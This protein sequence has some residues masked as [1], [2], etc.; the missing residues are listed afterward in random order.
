M[1]EPQ[2]DQTKD[3]LIAEARALRERLA[4]LESVI[5]TI[6]DAVYVKDLAGRYQVINSACARL[7]G[8]SVSEVI[9]KD[10][11]ELF[12]PGAAAFIMDTDRRVIA[13][14]TTIKFEVDASASG[15]NRSYLN[16][17]GPRFGT[18]DDVTGVIGIS[19]DVTEQ[20]RT[21]RELAR[22]AEM[23]WAIFEHIPVMIHLGEPDGRVKLVNRHWENVLGWPLEEARRI[24]IFAECYPDPEYRRQVL[25]CARNV[26]PGWH[27][28]RTRVRDGRVIDTSWTGTVLSD[29]TRIWFGQDVTDRK[30]GERELRTLTR[31]VVEVQEE[32]RRHLARELHDEIGQT[33]TA[34][35]IN[36]QAVKRSA[37]DSGSVGLD[38][39]INIV[40]RAI[41]QVRDLSLGLRPSVLDDLGLVAALRWHLDQQAQLVGYAAH[42]AA[43]PG[44]IALEPAA[45]IA[46]F[47][48]A[49]E[50]LTNVA[51]HA[52]A[53]RVA[54]KLR[55]RDETLQLAVL[56]DGVGFDP[57][58]NGA[59]LGLAGMRERAALLG[60]SVDVRSA[61]GRGTR[62][63]LKLAVEAGGDAC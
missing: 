49:Q 45:A 4:L 39:C 5:E 61:P 47:R 51:R 42:F 34:I 14:A 29:G 17:K 27:D 28:F 62:V 59:G 48:V 12:E 46:V 54:V 63:V 52:R 38:E 3:E 25:D 36:L 53:S 31:R 18:G 26:P 37:G 2:R 50:A 20:T 24:D 57:R 9:G 32:E 6:D 15:V 21:A 19:R 44:E 43:Q 8:R 33:L 10:D 7:L 56:D 35:G 30:R 55:F 58:A 11:S 60:G 40:G 41:Q 22:Q 16:T 23:L 1:H 13:T